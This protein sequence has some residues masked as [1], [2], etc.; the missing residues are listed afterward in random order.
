MLVVQ[1]RTC[2]PWFRSV[3]LLLHMHFC[4]FYPCNCYSQN[5]IILLAA[6][7]HHLH[8]ASTLLI[9]FSVTKYRVPV[10]KDVLN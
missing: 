10:G 2:L 5:F 4:T 3:L 1:I 6:A 9:L 7:Q 8:C